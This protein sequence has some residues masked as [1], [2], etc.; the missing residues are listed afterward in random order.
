MGI[1]VLVGI[2]DL[3]KVKV[4]LRFLQCGNNLYLLLPQII[5]IRSYYTFT[6][7]NNI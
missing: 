1:E 7:I 4:L 5:V 3:V 2:E 6:K